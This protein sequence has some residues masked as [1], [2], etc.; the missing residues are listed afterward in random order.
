MEAHPE[1]KN[2]DDI[3]HVTACG[4]D[5]SSDQIAQE[6]RIEDFLAL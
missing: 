3:S 4:M 1:C 2:I 5:N 6:V